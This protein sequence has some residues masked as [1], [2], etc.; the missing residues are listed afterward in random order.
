[1][2][3]QLAKRNK[4]LNE[5]LFIN[6][7]EEDSQAIG[8]RMFKIRLT[9]KKTGKKIDLI[10]GFVKKHVVTEEEIASGKLAFLA[11]TPTP[12]EP[13]AQ[14]ELTLP[15]PPIDG[16]AAGPDEELLAEMLGSGVGDGFSIQ[17]FPGDDGGGGDLG[18]MS[19][20]GGGGGGGIP[21][22]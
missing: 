9:S 22:Y 18:G 7:S 19:G 14:E 8:K 17:G 6:D 12:L 21:G 16:A 15:A 4:F 11:P 13:A 3:L 1:M 20:G 5:K 10:L 2:R